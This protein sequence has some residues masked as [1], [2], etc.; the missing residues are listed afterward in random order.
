MEA[1]SARVNDRPQPLFQFVHRG[2]LGQKEPIEARLCTRVCSAVLISRGHSWLLHD[3]KQVDTTVEAGKH[4]KTTSRNSRRAVHKT[5]KVFLLRAIKSILYHVPEIANHRAIRAFEHRVGL[6][7]GEDVIVHL[8]SAAEESADLFGSEA[9]TSC[10]QQHFWHDSTD[11][12]GE[13]LHLLVY[14]AGHQVIR[15][16]LEI[17][18]QIT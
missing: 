11:S 12:R 15:E 9:F 3:G 18:L 2:I 16:Q 8:L 10:T 5:K 1:E 6:P 14:A 13:R 17:H 7:I 4:C